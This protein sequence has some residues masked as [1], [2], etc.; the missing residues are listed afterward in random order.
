MTYD[1][2][3]RLTTRSADPK[4]NAARRMVQARRARRPKTVGAR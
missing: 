3:G 4:R 2:Y 1:A